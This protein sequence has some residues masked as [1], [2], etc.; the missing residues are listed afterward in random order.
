M[1]DDSD[2]IIALA[3]PPAR[4]SHKKTKIDSQKDSHLDAQKD[5]QKNDFTNVRKIVD[6]FNI[7]SKRK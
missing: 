3:Q 1:L 5:S 4:Y 6:I 7:L 2:E